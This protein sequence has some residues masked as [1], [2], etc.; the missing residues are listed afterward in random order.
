MW[1][2]VS[3]GNPLKDDAGNAPLAER[4]ARAREAAG[5]GAIMVTD[6]E[7]AMGTRYTV[8]TL[9]R[10]T[11]CFPRARFVWLMGADNLAQID[12][13]K[14]W[15]R[16]FR[17]VPVAIFDRAPY[18]TRALA[19]KAAHRFARHQLHGAHARRLA[20]CE[21]PAWSFFHARLHPE[22]ATAIRKRET[23]GRPPHTRRER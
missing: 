19:S 21:P 12:R 8:D 18:S 17:L 4:V 5:G 9:A 20:E 22:S 16:I 7:A 11:E 23:A 10:L 13:W 3:P 1:W 6:L 2:L 14:G 15:E